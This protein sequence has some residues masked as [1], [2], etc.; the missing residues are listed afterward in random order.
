MIK[1]CFVY[2]HD[3]PDGSGAAAMVN[4]LIGFSGARMDGF[5]NGEGGNTYVMVGSHETDYNDYGFDAHTHCDYVPSIIFIVDLSFSRHTIGSL[6]NL[7][8]TGKMVIWIDH[9]QSSIDIAKEMKEKLDSY[10]NLFYMLSNDLSGTALVEVFSAAIRGDLDRLYSIEKDDHE[11]IQT[12]KGIHQFSYD[13]DKIKS[14]KYVVHRFLGRDYEI[15]RFA[16]YIDQ[17]DRW[18]KQDPDADYFVQGLRLRGYKFRNGENAIYHALCESF[19]VYND[20]DIDTMI[21]EGKLAMRANN[22]LMEDQ[23]DRV[24]KVDFTDGTIYMKMCCGNSLNFCHLS[25]A[26]ETAF[27]MVVGWDVKLN[28]FSCS[29]YRNNKNADKLTITAKEIADLFGG[30]GHDGAAG[31][32]TNLNMM[33][34]LPKYAYGRTMRQALKALSFIETGEHH[35]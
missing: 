21:R 27:V 7:V 9:H 35:E 4:N 13:Y 5:I 6:L 30:G 22:M 34:M 23:L 1:N 15:S 28:K 16:Y 3:D 33:D 19:N 26:P 11:L 14:G 10:K 18:T 20:G 24:L 17:Y 32:K 29:I 25:D 12:L 2:Y 8:N 31:F